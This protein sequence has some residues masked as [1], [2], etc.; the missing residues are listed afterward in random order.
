M[1]EIIHVEQLT[2]KYGSLNA[3]KD[4]TFSVRRGEIFGLLGP[5]GAGK[6]TT[7]EILQGLRTYDSGTVRVL[8]L[9][10]RTQAAELRRRMGSQLQ[11]AALPDRI[12]VWEALDFFASLTP[13]KVDWLELMRQWGLAEK[14]N[15]SFADL[16]G[17]QRQRLFVALALINKP[18]VVFLDEMTTGLDPGSRH[19]AWDLIRQI[20]DNGTTVVLVTHF[21]DEAENLCDRLAVIDRG[22]VTAM[23]SPQ[24]L[25]A[26]YSQGIKLI[27]STAQA[28]LA[29]LKGIP[30]VRQI[31]RYGERV[32]VQGTGTVVVQVCAKLAAHN[33]IPADVRVE[34]PTLEDAFLAITGRRE[35]QL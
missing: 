8:G 24:G 13:G 22:R 20:R 14:K 27:F 33:I 5:N 32:E 30:E 9:D 16:S 1:N 15:A 2:K 4:V 26:T 31:T 28:D 10:P 11:E 34:Q 7:V 29:W 17:G 3:L 23:D 18:E 21:M 35:M 12:K 19:L 6:T 25:I